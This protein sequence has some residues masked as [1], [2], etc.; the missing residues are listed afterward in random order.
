M[1]ADEQEVLVDI[2]RSG[3]T[4]ATHPKL[5]C[6]RAV[7]THGVVRAQRSEVRQRSAVRERRPWPTFNV[8]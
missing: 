2:C 8:G 6:D 3:H 1:D 5:L 4:A 7:P